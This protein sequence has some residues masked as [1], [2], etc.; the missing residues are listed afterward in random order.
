M[1]PFISQNPNVHAEVYIQS[2][3]AADPCVNNIVINV[4]SPAECSAVAGSTASVNIVDTREGSAAAGSSAVEPKKGVVDVIEDV[5]VSREVALALMRGQPRVVIERLDIDSDDM[6]V[7]STYSARSAS[8]SSS[9]TKR[10]R[11]E[12]DD[13]GESSD[14]SVASPKI[15]KATHG[16]CARGRGRS[17]ATA[18]ELL[19]SSTAQRRQ[20]VDAEEEE[21]AM[22]YSRRIRR[23][24]ERAKY[25]AKDI[26]LGEIVQNIRTATDAIIVLANKSR[27]L[28]GT[29]EG[30]LKDAASSIAG[31]VETIFERTANEEVRRLQAENKRLAEELDLLRQKPAQ[32]EGPAVL[33]APSPSHRTDPDDAVVQKAV[34]RVLFIL[35]ARSA[36]VTRSRP[37]L[38]AERKKGSVLPDPSPA[39]SS[40]TKA[41]KRIES[42]VSAMSNPQTGPKT[43]T[44]K[45]AITASSS[46]P[47]PASSK[48]KGKGKKTATVPAPSQIVTDPLPPVPA[49]EPMDAEWATVVKRGRRKPATKNLT[50]P[51]KQAMSA[52]PPKPGKPA[53][54]AKSSGQPKSAGPGRHEGKPKRVR[55]PRTAAIYVKFTPA[56]ARCG[57]TY[58]K[59]L[60]E[61]RRRVDLAEIGITSGITW[62]KAQD[63]ARLLVVA[64]HDADA[65]ADKLA[66]A[67][68]EL[69]HNQPGSAQDGARLLVVAGHDANAKADKLAA[70]LRELPHNQPGSVTIARPMKRAD[71]RLK[72]FDDSVTEADVAAAIAAKCECPPE[73]VSVGKISANGDFRTVVVKV[74]LKAAKQ[75][76]LSR[77][78]LIG[79][80]SAQVSLLA[81][82][83]KR[84]LRCLGEGHVANKCLAAVS[85][86]EE[87]LRCG[88]VGHKIKEC[89]AEKPKCS[90]CAAAGKPA[91][92]SLGTKNCPQPAQ[93]SRAEAKSS[94][95]KKPPLERLGWTWRWSPWRILSPARCPSPVPAF[96]SLSSGGGSWT[97]GW[98]RG[99]PPPSKVL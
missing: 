7:V 36:P 18:K 65:K 85:R 28:K 57:M 33:S 17:P 80:S 61:S 82:R 64:G 88:Q 5:G 25:S 24:Q 31:A 44:K 47:A 37:P 60:I 13:D 94:W 56:A 55:I 75:L 77:Q 48:G 34:E 97:G 30:A 72:G 51:A 6:S 11:H 58:E 12:S 87:C 92:H 71:I 10:L 91:G 59:F 76:A 43:A 29:T 93:L 90:F 98:T 40:A 21:V 54:A 70:A 73:H 32:E 99:R 49:S 3:L 74:P 46:S 26:T 78:L 19:S 38:T 23:A 69:P 68:R 41:G 45:A 4:D 53:K 8:R 83:P 42:A 1:D 2:V 35:E 9:R 22:E 14:S 67:L 39:S 89:T 95:P 81:S 86:S 66:A 16:R 50:E 15:P 52:N 20:L 27:H 62:R 63:G 84:C 79:W 96:T